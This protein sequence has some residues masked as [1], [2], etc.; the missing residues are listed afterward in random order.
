MILMVLLAQVELLRIYGEVGPCSKRTAM[1]LKSLFSTSVPH[2]K[3]LAR[4]YQVIGSLTTSINPHLTRMSQVSRQ[5]KY[6]SR[7]LIFN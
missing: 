3:L 1:V 6:A 7:G 4:F 5:R 2:N